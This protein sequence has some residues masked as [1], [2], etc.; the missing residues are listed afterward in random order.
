MQTIYN[1]TYTQLENLLESKGEKRFRAKQIWTWLYRKRITELNEMTDIKKSLI[2]ELE[3]EFYISPLTLTTKQKSKDGTIKFLF[4]TYDGSLLE[5][6]LMTFS[7]GK[8]LC[9]TSQ[10]GCSMGCT[11]CASG[12][13]KKQRDLASGEIVAQVLYAQKYLDKYEERVSNIVVMGTGE[14]F[15]NYDNVMNFCDTINSDLG[16]AIGARKITISTC[17]VVEG[18]YDFANEHKQY[19][20][21]IS[22]H[23]P[24]D[25]LR[26]ELMPINK[27]HN[28]DELMEA[29]DYYS[30]ENNRRITLEYILLHG[31]NDTKEMAMKLA[32]LVKGRNAYINLI[33]YNA[34]DEN[35]FKKTDEKSAFKFYD[36]LMKNG[37]KATLRQEHGGDIDG[38]CGQLRAKYHKKGE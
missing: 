38:A 19:N 24:D 8:S 29:L 35:S 15:D 6:V 2:E 9:V 17:G 25:K 4:K 16:L 1:L 5:A 10:I 28:I 21:A 12:L 33:P 7:Y 31:I 26:S 3:K 11:F 30:K 22:L 18:I 20:L 32:E 37:V 27:V 13:L 23:A 36:L 14:P 34:V